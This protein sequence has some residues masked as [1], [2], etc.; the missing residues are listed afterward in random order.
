MQPAEFGWGFCFV[1]SNAITKNYGLN[2]NMG[3]VSA[4]IGVMML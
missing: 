3:F 4:E 2:Y 1:L